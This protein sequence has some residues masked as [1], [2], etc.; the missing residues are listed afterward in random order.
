MDANRVV[1]D[2]GVDADGN[3]VTV[4]KYWDAET[5]KYWAKD[6]TVYQQSQLYHADMYIIAIGGND[7]KRCNWTADNTFREDYRALIEE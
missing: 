5:G 4:E 7:A 6:Y 2:S 1:I 3:P